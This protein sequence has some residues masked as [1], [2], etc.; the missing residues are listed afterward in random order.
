[1][2]KASRTKRRAGVK[3]ARKS[4]GNWMWWAISGVII[5]GA[6]ALIFV[7]REEPSAPLANKD[8]WHA[9]L[10]VNVCGEW[11]ENAPEFH[12]SAEN[13]AQQAGLHSHG[14]GLIHIHPYVSAE[15]GDNATVGQ[16]LE[17]GGWSAD[18][19]SFRLW[20]GTEHAAGDKCGDNEATVRWELNGEPQS[21][22]ISSYRPENND[23]IALA[24]LPEGEQIGEPPSVEALAAPSDV[25]PS[26]TAPPATTGTTLPGTPTTAPGDTTPTTV[27]AVTPVPDATTTPAP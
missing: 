1:M 5:V 20:D 26:G 3:S 16:F 8:H 14:D 10:G 25:E 18:E 11:L 9:A 19:D 13:D 6:V 15:S 2:G 23:I 12:S 7:S 17:Y 21:G 4:R 24:L 22:N 27:A